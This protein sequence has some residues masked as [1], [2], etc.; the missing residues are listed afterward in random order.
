LPTG[1]RDARGFG[2]AQAERF[3]AFLAD[4]TPGMGRVFH[5][6]CGLVDL[7]GQTLAEHSKRGFE[8]VE[9]GRGPQIEQTV[10]L[11]QTAIQP[12]CR[13]GLPQACASPRLQ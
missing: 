6:L 2:N 4:Y 3:Q 10:H 9:A 5:G 8:L 12:A 13:F 7:D 11:W 1:F